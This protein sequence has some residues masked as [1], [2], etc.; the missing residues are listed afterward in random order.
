MRSPLPWSRTAAFARL[1][2]GPG[3]ASARIGPPTRIANPW[4]AAAPRRVGS[5]ISS[6]S[7][8]KRWR[9][10]SS[11]RVQPVRHISGATSRLAPAAAASAAAAMTMSRL[12]CSRPSTGANWTIATRTAG[13]QPPARL[14]KTVSPEKRLVTPADGQ[15]LRQDLDRPVAVHDDHVLE[16]CGAPVATDL[17]LDRPD[18]S[19]GDRHAFVG[20]VPGEP[21]VVEG[22][23]VLVS[24]A[25]KA[26][27][28]CD[29]VGEAVFDEVR[30][31]HVEELA[32]GNS[33][34]HRPDHC[35]DAAGRSV[36][37]LRLPVGRVVSG[38]PR[39]DDVVDVAV[40]VAVVVRVDDVANRIGSRRVPAR[41]P[42][43]LEVS[44][45]S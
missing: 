30:L 5:A 3:G 2:P 14:P 43:V 26:R 20:R 23:A 24:E 45:A 27:V 34:S 6:T 12:G 19:R 35:A 36:D 16:P 13:R 31:A 28:E 44:R 9:T 17:D 21:R 42:G 4:A 33:H 38:H 39:P 25:G 32:G 7:L 8:A 41:Q 10:A 11:R 29:F 22:V 15:I 37:D 18:G 40:R 1:K